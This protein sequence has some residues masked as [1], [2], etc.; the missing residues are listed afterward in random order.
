MSSTPNQMSASDESSTPD[1]KPATE[2]LVQ[3]VPMNR[4]VV[5]VCLATL[6]A[7]ADLWT[8]YAV[9][10]WLGPPNL[11]ASGR[12]VYWL[13]EGYVG[14]ETAVNIGA[15]AGIG[16]G[17]GHF[18]A[19][20]SVVAGVFILYWLFYRGAANQWLLTVA[21][22]CVMAGIIGNLYD[23]LG[24]WWKPGMPEAWKSGVRDWILFQ[25][26]DRWVWPNFNIA[27]SLLVCG[28]GLLIWRSFFPEDEQRGESTSENESGDL[29]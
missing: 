11:Y 28:A 21:L 22:G 7:T 8:K 12:Q 26:S 5:F 18:F 27:D 2:S 14:I 6:G 13:I 20:M 9:F 24:M 23:R 1:S 25:A 15:V 29:G 3:S 10:D 19:L 16:A 17:K 4:I